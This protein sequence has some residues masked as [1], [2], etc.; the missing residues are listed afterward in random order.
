[1]RWKSL[2]SVGILASLAWIGAL[3]AG[4]ETA[5]RSADPL[6]DKAVALAARMED[7]K[8]TP[9]RMDI[10]AVVK[11]KDG[12]VED[13]SEM[14]YRVLGWGEDTRMELISARENGK[15]ITEKVREAERKEQAERAAKE[16]QKKG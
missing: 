16:K 12:S 1:M 4:P 8:L 14:S 6:W 10:Q 15:D 13:T 5:P 7:L 3:A 2:K 9:G 11:K